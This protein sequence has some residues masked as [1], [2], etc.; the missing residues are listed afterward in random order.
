[1]VV[2]RKRKRFRRCV[3]SRIIGL[4]FR[5]RYIYIRL[6]FFKLNIGGI[7]NFVLFG[8]VFGRIEE[9]IIV[10]RYEL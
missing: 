10:L 9:L 1:M 8:N 4:C 7:G 3:G 5:F 6:L 2:G